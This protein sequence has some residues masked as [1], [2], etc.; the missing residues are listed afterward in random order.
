MNNKRTKT[1]TAPTNK[2]CSNREAQ[3][4]AEIWEINTW[5]L[6]ITF[7]AS[8]L[9][10]YYY[11]LYDK[12]EDNRVLRLAN[13]DQRTIQQFVFLSF[14]FSLVSFISHQKSRWNLFFSFCYL[15]GKKRPSNLL[16]IFRNILVWFGHPFV[17]LTM[18]MTR[19][20]SLAWCR[21]QTKSK[22]KNIL[23]IL[24]TSFA[25]DFHKSKHSHR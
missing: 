2:I 22:L 10:P 4:E 13:S 21:P 14:F 3:T 19:T 9:V 12:W 5:T 11:F 1:I 23:E 24:C 20:D 8:C 15:H 17:W 16:F 7:T 25:L 6:N 18:T